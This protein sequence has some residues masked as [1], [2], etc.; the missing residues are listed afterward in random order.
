VVCLSV[1]R[2]VTLVSPAKTAGPVEMPFGLRTRVGLRNHVLDGA[3][4]PMR[5][6]VFTGK[7]M[8]ADLSPLAAANELV[9]RLRC[10]GIIARVERVYSS[11]RGVRC[12][13]SSN[14]F[15]HLFLLLPHVMRRLV[16]SCFL[17]LTLS[18]KSTKFGS[19]YLIDRFSE[20]DKIWHIDRW[21]LA[22]RHFQHW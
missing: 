22:V 13:L 6:A 17:S 7:V 11:S 18:T 19:R 2:S 8:S 3:R 21:G 1:C 12:G 20:R 15:D 4:S 9:C 10:G 14:Y 16:I 5:G